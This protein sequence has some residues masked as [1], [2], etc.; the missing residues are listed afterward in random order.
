M[1]QE[2]KV[3]LA[4]GSGGELSHRLI[5]NFFL[6][7]FSNPIL[8]ALDDA[9]VLEVG[10][11]L[12]FSTDSYVVK[13]LFW[14]GGD[15]G[16][17]AVCGTVNDLSMS[18]AIPLFLSAGFILEEGFPLELLSR[19]LNS[20][21]EAAEEAG[22]KLVAGDTKVVEKGKA[23]NLFINTSGLGLIEERINISGRNAQLGDLVILS[24]TIGDH[25]IAVISER[26][27]IDLG[28]EVE[29]D[30]APLNH[31][32]RAILKACPKIHCLRD[33]TRGGL[34]TTL[35]EIASQSDVGIVIWEDKIPINEGVKAA[36]ELLG[37]DPLYLANE[38]KLVAIVPRAEGEKV[39][40]V[41]KENRYGKKASIIGE[42]V[43]T[44][45][46]K[47]LMKTS[48]G[49]TRV[50]NMLAGEMLPRIC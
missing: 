15:I 16:R 39:L 29:S 38:G 17:L 28:V 35:N 26:E 34:A 7:P 11:R 19:I 45:R 23:D 24:G 33:P 43:A 14:K 12:A 20:M 50:V 2:K 44:P 46:K 25:S 1:G 48:I 21:K 37:Y 5:R 42:V 47:V 27:G 31:L 4:H 6:P 8:E 49:G 32:V 40:Q 22:V 36:C 3:L 10:V 9:A 18:G 13:P 41:M 30:V